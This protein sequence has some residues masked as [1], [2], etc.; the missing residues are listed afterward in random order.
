MYYR[1]LCFVAV[2]CSVSVFGQNNAP[3][4][5]PTPA[6]FHWTSGAPGSDAADVQ[7]SHILMEKSTDGEVAISIRPV[8][9]YIRAYV[10]LLNYDKDPVNF[11]PMKATLLMTAPKEKVYEAINPEKAAKG[12]ESDAEDAARTPT[13]AGCAMMIAQCQPTDS[14]MNMGKDARAIGANEAALARKDGMKQP[15]TLKQNDQEQGAIYFKP[16]HK[17]KEMVIRIPLGTGIYEFP[18]TLGKK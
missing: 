7:G 11:D 15:I 10:Q 16:D 8:G 17:V 13:D 5:A 4:P 12:I 18:F 14:A 3:T 1:I 6:V 2:L 9:Q